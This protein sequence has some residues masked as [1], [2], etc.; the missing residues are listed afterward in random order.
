M[1]IQTVMHLVC[2]MDDWMV[3][4]KASLTE[5]PLEIHLAL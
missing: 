5:T 2:S 3:K 1:A 4:L